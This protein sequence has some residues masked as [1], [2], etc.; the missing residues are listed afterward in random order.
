MSIRKLKPHLKSTATAILAFAITISSSIVY[1]DSNQTNQTNQT[2]VYTGYPYKNVAPWF[3]T[4]I[5]EA[6]AWKVIPDR[7]RKLAMDQPITRGEFA[8]ALVLA[9]LS[10]TGELPEDWDHNRFADE[11]NAYAKVASELGLVSGYDDGTFRS[12][13]YIKREE[14]FAMIQKLIVKMESEVALEGLSTEA[15]LSTFGDSAAVSSWAK[16]ATALMVAKQIV[17]GT[18]KKTLEP[19]QSTTRAQALVILNNALK[20]LGDGPVSSRKIN[21]AFD[22]FVE[23]AKRKI[24]EGKYAVAKT[25]A[26]TEAASEASTEAASEGAAET[27]T[28]EPIVAKGFNFDSI[29]TDPSMVAAQNQSN[30]TVVSRGGRRDYRSLED[31]YTPEEM[32][33]MLGN[34][35]VKYGL[36][37]GSPTAERYQTS[38]EALKHMV[39]VTVDVWQLGASGVKTTGKRN[40]M[41]NKAIADTVITVFKEIYEGPEQYPIKDVGGYA[42]R[43]SPTSEHRWGL[44][45]DLNANENYMIRKDGTIVAGSF[46]LPGENPYSIRPDGDVVRAFKKHGFTWG[47]DA[48]PMSNDYMHFSFLGE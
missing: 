25:E 18:D 11:P 5:K 17:S 44:A 3:E 27:S 22:R 8:E 2:K 6:E 23:T 10:L 12:T 13:G 42:W 37:F 14:M 43:S 47:G 36:I 16:D 33:V 32:L 31:I 29:F 48:W 19:K 7:F 30:T 28:T 46:W 34:N 20:T 21:S 40:I 24:V 15:V 39:T 41:V 26:S 35:S 9:Y 38:A 4:G 1:A 45:I